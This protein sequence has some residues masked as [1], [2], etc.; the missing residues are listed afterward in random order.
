MVK[1]ETGTVKLQIAAGKA[2]PARPVGP[3]LAQAQINIMEFCKQFDDR[4]NHEELEGLVIPIGVTVYDDS[5]T[6]KIGGR[7]SNQ[8][9]I[10]EKHHERAAGGGS[11]C[12]SVEGRRSA[13]A[14]R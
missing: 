13:A 5:G 7:R 11:A 14:K 8:E 10:R 9:A 4:P 1:K 3:A 6:A 2:T 12:V